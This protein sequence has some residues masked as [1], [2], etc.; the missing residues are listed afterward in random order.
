MT[1]TAE[2]RHAEQWRALRDLSWL[3]TILE[4]QVTLEGGT[5]KAR[6]IIFKDGEVRPWPILAYRGE[7]LE[8]ARAAIK[9][10]APTYLSLPRLAHEGSEVVE[11]W[12]EPMMRGRPYLTEEERAAALDDELAALR[13]R[14]G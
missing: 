9:K 2:E 4:Y 13:G 1:R 3:R 8:G 6:L 11:T 7:S 14:V 12:M 10:L 5:Y